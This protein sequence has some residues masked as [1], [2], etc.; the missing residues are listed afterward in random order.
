MQQL[1]LGASNKKG[2]H[3]RRETAPLSFPYGVSDA[4]KKLKKAH[5]HEH[6]RMQ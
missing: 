3:G 4:N 2:H 1:H 5:T 6:P